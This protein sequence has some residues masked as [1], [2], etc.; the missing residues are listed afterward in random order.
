MLEG[1]SAHSY[2]F[3]FRGIGYTGRC[4]PAIRRLVSTWYATLL[5]RVLETK[6]STTC[7]AG[8][9]GR[10]VLYGIFGTAA[11]NVGSH[12][13]RD[14]LHCVIIAAVLVNLY[15]NGGMSIMWRVDSGCSVTC[16]VVRGQ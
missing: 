1:R 13:L 4:I 6:P 2:V 8:I 11:G 10:A 14:L 15:V 9:V 16:P 5:G 7:G 3:G 12:F